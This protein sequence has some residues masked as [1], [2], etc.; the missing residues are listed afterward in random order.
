LRSLSYAEAS[1]FY[2]VLSSALTIY[3]VKPI[4]KNLINSARLQAGLSGLE[5][6]LVHGLIS[7]RLVHS[8]QL[9]PAIEL[10]VLPQ[11]IRT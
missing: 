7:I 1:F 8:E 10:D 11:A 9:E 2:F 5:Q 3:V 6:T 4:I